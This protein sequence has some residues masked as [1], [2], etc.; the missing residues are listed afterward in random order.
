MTLP[1]CLSAIAAQKVPEPYISAIAAEYV[2][3]GREERE[4]AQ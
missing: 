2:R 3:G 4:R 1:D